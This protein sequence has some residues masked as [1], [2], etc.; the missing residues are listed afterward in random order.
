[1]TDLS[2]EQHAV[3][4]RFRSDALRAE[5]DKIISLVTQDEFA[6]RVSAVLAAPPSEQLDLAAQTMSP[7]ALRAAGLP[8][9][10]NARVSSR[11]FEEGGNL[12]HDLGD[13]SA[14]KNSTISLPDS[15]TVALSPDF[16]KY[17]VG[18]VTKQITAAGID[19]WSV[20][21]CVGAGGCVGVG[22]G[23]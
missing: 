16:G 11:Y 6:S 22:G 5:T 3:L 12:S 20:C 18:D 8:V 14:G 2:P 1:M 23:T 19:E 4:N 17:R 21:L 10:D 9:P 15:A 13:G 7:A